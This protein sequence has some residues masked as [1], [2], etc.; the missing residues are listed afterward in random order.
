MTTIQ[1]EAA[2]LLVSLAVAACEPAPSPDADADA[3]ENGLHPAVLVAGEEIETRSIA[4]AMETRGVPGMSV[5]VVDGGRLAWARAYGVQDRRTGAPV[6][7]T[8]LFQAAS[9]SKPVAALAALQLV[10][11]GTLTLDD[12]VSRWLTS[13]QVPP[14]EDH[15][16]DVSLRRLLTHSAGLTVHGFPGYERGERVP[17]T[18][19]VL[20]GE[21]NTSPIRVDTVPGTMWRYSG[22]GYTVLQL[23]LEDVTGRPFPDLLHERVLEPLGMTQSAYAQPLPDARAGQAATGYRSNGD[24]VV[25]DWHTYP[26][27]AAAGLWTTPTDLMRYALGVHAAL[28]GEDGA[29]LS[30]DMARE[31]LTAGIGGWGL[32]PAVAGSGDDLRFSHGGGN[33]GFRCFVVG[34]PNRG[35]G[36]AV[37]TN[38]DTGGG[39]AQEVLRSIARA[40]DWPE[41]TAR[42]ITEAPLEAGEAEAYAGRY[43]IPG[44]DAF[45]VATPEDGR[46][47]V[48]VPGEPEQT[49]AR[50]EG[51]TF[52]DLA[53]GGEITFERDE[54]GAVVAVRG[55][56]MRLAKEG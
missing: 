34:W 9:I 52:V 33:E 39:L 24:A 1:R 17:S 50:T 29:V 41:Y 35:Q 21:G 40:Y 56:G 12:D 55:R 18:I 36:A 53:N 25:G 7:D 4:Q 54:A 30:E 31:M 48:A 13:W 3:V 38:S 47:R 51:D 37:M 49:Y 11:E 32:G 26:E 15:P 20:D 5:A 28:N 46:L 2:I 8:T 23:L 42:T 10:E 44:Q 27:M 19:E 6:T 14:H 22:G 43:R 16:G 45:V